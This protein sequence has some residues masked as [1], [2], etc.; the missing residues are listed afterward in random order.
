MFRSASGNKLLNAIKLNLLEV[1]KSIFERKTSSSF[2][3][4]CNNI[5]FA[6]MYTYAVIKCN[7]R[8]IPNKKINNRYWYCHKTIGTVIKLQ[9]YQVS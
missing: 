5:S 1:R 3:M 4:K 7:L 2:P 8:E 6:Y 9:H